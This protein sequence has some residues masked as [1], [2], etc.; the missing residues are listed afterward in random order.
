MRLATQA[1]L[2]KKAEDLVVLDVQGRVSYCDWFILCNGTSN[3]QVQAIANH[4]V[5]SLKKLGVRPM[6]VEGLPSARWVL[7]DLGDVVLHVFEEPLR[8]YYDLDGLWIDARRVGL[9]ELGIE[10]PTRQGGEAA[11]SV[12]AR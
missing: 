4:V 1:A 11:T 7:I 12:F 6:G 9:D 2:D 3:R 10:P 5:E 8:G